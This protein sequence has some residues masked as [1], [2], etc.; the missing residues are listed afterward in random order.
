MHAQQ[1]AVEVQHGD[2]VAILSQVLDVLSP[3]DVDLLELHQVQKRLQLFDKLIAQR[4][5]ALRVQR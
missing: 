4:T 2:V 3:S 1:R 5:R